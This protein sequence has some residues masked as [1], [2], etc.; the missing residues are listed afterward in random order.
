[1]NIYN[2]GSRKQISF[3]D[4][5]TRLSKKVEELSIIVKKLQ[6]QSEDKQ[7][8]PCP[9]CSTKTIGGGACAECSMNSVL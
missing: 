1:M 2:T 7:K 8:K 5:I 6:A 4:R 9:H 3:D